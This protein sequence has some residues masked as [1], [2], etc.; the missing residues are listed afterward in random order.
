V[1]LSEDSLE[2]T[3]E[4]EKKYRSVFKNRNWY[5]PYHEVAGR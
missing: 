5:K 4:E 2:R 1:T 3:L